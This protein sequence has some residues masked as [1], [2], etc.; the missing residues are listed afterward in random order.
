[1]SVIINKIPTTDPRLGRHQEHDDASFRFA[2]TAAPPPKP[3]TVIHDDAAPVLNQGHVGGCVGWTGA[4]ILDTAL[5]TPVRNTK[6]GSMY[7]NDADGLAFYTLATHKDNI[8]GFYPNEDTGSSGLGLAKALKYLGLIDRYLHC[9]SWTQYLAA[10]A[11]QPVAV[12]TLWTNK[13]FTPDNNGVVRVGAL[14]N[15]TIAGGHEYM[16]RGHDEER[17]LNLCRNHWTP[18]WDKQ[19]NLPKLPGE[20]WLPDQDLQ[21][22]LKNQGDVT[23]LHGAGLP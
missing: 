15:S 4:D 9:F 21:L 1:M 13:M 12:G 23:V 8:A 16:I 7:F 5:Y 11:H 2:Y 6:N 19:G 14:N 3:V 20:F 17:G 22:L 10:I 18:K